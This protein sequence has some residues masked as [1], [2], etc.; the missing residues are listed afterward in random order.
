MGL[1]MLSN[2]SPK[3]EHCF[4]CH[5][6][7]IYLTDNI[8][9]VSQMDTAGVVADQQRTQLVGVIIG[10]VVVVVVEV[11][12]VTELSKFVLGEQIERMCPEL[13]LVATEHLG[14]R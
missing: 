4:I 1:I 6:L 11:A 8:G 5:S 9:I 10:F 2:P 7:K 14:R 13:E 12:A 3:F